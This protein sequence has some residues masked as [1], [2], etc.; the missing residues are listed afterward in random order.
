MRNIELIRKVLLFTQFSASPRLKT[1]SQPAINS[2]NLKEIYNHPL[3]HESF[4][5]LCAI[6]P[7]FSGIVFSSSQ[8][9]FRNLNEIL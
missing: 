5:K 8:D 7:I 1:S 6:I 9:A 2:H 3:A 4:M